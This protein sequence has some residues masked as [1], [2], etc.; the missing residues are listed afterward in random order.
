MKKFLCCLIFA[1][2]TVLCFAQEKLPFTKGVNLTNF[3]EYWGDQPGIALPTMNKYDEADFICLKSMGV[4]VIRIVCNFDIYSEESFGIGKIDEVF[5]KKLD[6]ICDWAERNQMYLIIDN[7]NNKTFDND[8]HRNNYAKLKAHLESVWS[9]LAPRYANRSEYIIYEI[10]NE[11]N[12]QNAGKWYKLQQEIVNLIRSYDSKHTI[13]VSGVNWSNITEL[14]QF[15]PYKDDNLIYT[16][17]FYEP[18]FFTHQGATG[19]ATTNRLENVPFP[20]DQKRFPKLPDDLS[21]FKERYRTEGTV[22][23]INTRIKKAADWAKKNNV[24]MFCGE[25]GPKIWINT[26]DRILWISTV[27]SALNENNIPYLSWSIDDSTGFLKNSYVVRG[28]EHAYGVYFPDDIDS[29]VAQAYGFNMPSSAALAMTNEPL[30]KFPQTPYVVFDDLEGKITS[31]SPYNTKAT[32]L[33]DSHGV[34]FVTSYP[35]EKANIEINLPKAI[36]SKFEKN[37]NSLAVCFDVKFTDKSQTFEILLV[38]SDGGKNEL[39]W[40]KRHDMKASD[41]ALNEWVT[42][43]IPLSNFYDNWGAWS[44]VDQNWYN[45]PCEF[46][47]SRF[48]KLSFNFNDHTSGT[49]KGEVYIDNIVIKKK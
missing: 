36:T 13:V 39:P 22:K 44:Q 27:V 30:K 7:H 38:D 49:S 29:A 19:D 8:T 5:L 42:V 4:D 14:A 16:F 20:Y 3:L 15:K 47:W 21:W 31:I 24:K 6:E 43:K 28:D 34:C 10:M 17:H 33:N 48:E 37:K 46:T 45:L 40:S 25:L 41:Y 11:P 18:F 1:C 23:Y 2:C 12:I 32:K 35:Q 9:Q 26:E